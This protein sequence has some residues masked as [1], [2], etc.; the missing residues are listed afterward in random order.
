MTE[1]VIIYFNIFNC[2]RNI[3]DQLD[4]KYQQLFI[5]TAAENDYYK[6]MLRN[7]I[8]VD[9]N[10]GGLLCNEKLRQAVIY[11]R[12]EINIEHER[13]INNITCDDLYQYPMK[14]YMYQQSMI[15]YIMSRMST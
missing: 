10:K 13:N 11:L 4:V 8:K 6:D 2:G 1:K 9:N 15:P 5:S 12:A 7:I 3:L 14:K